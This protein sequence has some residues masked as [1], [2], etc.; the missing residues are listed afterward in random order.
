MS[1]RIHRKVDGLL[2][3]KDSGEAR[4]LSAWERIALFFGM[5]NADALAAKGESV[6]ASN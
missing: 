6:W 3:I 2:L 5:T 4:F 1:T